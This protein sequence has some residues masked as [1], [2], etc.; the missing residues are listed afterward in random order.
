[1]PNDASDV[2]PDTVLVDAGRLR[3]VAVHMCDCPLATQS[4]RETI[5][6]LLNSWIEQ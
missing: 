4:D 2:G 1:M 6:E 5:L 3:A